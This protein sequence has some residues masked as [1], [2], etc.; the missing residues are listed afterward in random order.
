MNST[1]SRVSRHLPPEARLALVRASQTP[2][3][4]TDSMARV[5]ALEKAIALVLF[6]YPHYFKKEES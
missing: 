3:P 6:L 4:D 5:R 2:I 1:S